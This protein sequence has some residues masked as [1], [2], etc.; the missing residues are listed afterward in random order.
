MKKPIDVPTRATAEFLSAHLPARSRI[1]EI[2]CGEGHVARELL[3]R[4]YE[5]TGVDP[6]PEAV[7][8]AKRMGVA[9]VEAAWPEFECAD[10]D[11]VVFTRSLHH[12][13]PL[14][15]AVRRAHQVLRPEG[16]LLVEDFAFDEADDATIEWFLEMVKSKAG[17]T[18]IKL[19]PDEFV[20]DL[21]GAGDPLA[22]WHEGHDHDLHTLSAM[23]QAIAEQFLIH[24]TPAI[25]YLYRYLVPVLPETVEAATFVENVFHEE[26]IRGKRGEIVLVGRR[27]AGTAR[28]DSP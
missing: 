19:I 20:T 8:R 23:K 13:S 24:N 26:A 10:V 18:L 21:L 5:V 2:G 27:I 1:L 25:P 28:E 14:P 3:N 15:D 22:A 12:I 17:R 6:D 11:A 7:R 9:A 4:G 16:R